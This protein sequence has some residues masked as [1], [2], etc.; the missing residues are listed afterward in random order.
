MKGTVLLRAAAL[1]LLLPAAGVAQEHVVVRPEPGT[2]VVAVEVL[3]AV[4][5]ADETPEQAG[6]AYLTAR[7]ATA[8]IR[9]ILDSLGARLVVQG[10]KDALSFTLTA[11]PDAWREAS[12]TLLVALFRDPADS[13]ATMRERAA[14]AADLVGREASPADA[15]SRQVDRAAFGPDHPWGRPA[16]G[17][18]STVRTLTPADVHDFIRARFV[19]ERTAVAVV[20][21]VVAEEARAHLRGFFQGAPWDAPRVEPGAPLESPVREEYNSITTWVAAVYPFPAD[22]DEEA[23][24]LLAELVTEGLSFGPSRSSVYNAR[25]EVARRPGGGELR[26][27]LV[28]PP[29]EADAWARRIPEAVAGYAENALSPAVFRERLR[30]H[31]GLRLREMDTPEA[32][33]QAAARAVLLGR[34]GSVRPADMGGLDPER[35]RSTARSLGEPMLVLLGP[36]LESSASTASDTTTAR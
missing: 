18:S 22:A 33:A 15:L 25:S 32:R 34:D 9:P 14:I 10:H 16:V 5:P 30:R 20:G 19:P 11:A 17:Y 7:A 31:R 1:A 28:V 21:P 36:F 13:A 2:P 6:L 3:V 29:G 24:R 23:V 8:P 12:Q 4:G 26:I 27:Q 35:L